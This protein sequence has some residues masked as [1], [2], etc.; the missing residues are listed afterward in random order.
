MQAGILYN[1]LCLEHDTGQHPENAGR[2]TAVVDHLRRVGLWERLTHLPSVLAPLSAVEAVHDPDYLALI[3]HYAERGGGHLTGD[4]PFSG[5]S[6]DA[7]LA[8]SGAAIGAVDAVLDG[9]VPAAFALVRP[10]GHHACIAEGMGFCLINHTAIAARH[11]VRTRGLSHVLLVDFDVHHGNGTQEIF[12]DDPSVLYYSHHQYPAYPGTGARTEIGR[13]KA[14]GTTVNVPLPGGTGDS[15]FLKAL[16]EVLA[17][18]AREYQPELI[19]VSAGYDAHW[20]NA[21]YLSGVHT[22]A[23]VAGFGQWVSLLRSL[24]A[25]LCG[26]RLAFVLEGG[27][28][29]E[30]L[31]WS[32][33]ATFRVLLGEPVQDPLGPSPSPREPFVDDIIEEC[34]RLHHLDG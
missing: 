8:A 5:R 31:A 14:L 28:D 6:W 23:T 22:A 4:T 19:L 13:G 21:R 26:G 24:A 15:G 10:P 1:P 2:L 34:R 11:A 9:T 7:V 16:T 30:A 18:V 12:Y 27:Y 32:V 3:R 20:T 33:D 29:P 25:E 17:P